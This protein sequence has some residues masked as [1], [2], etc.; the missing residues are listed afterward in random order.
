MAEIAIVPGQPLEISVDASITIDRVWFTVKKEQIDSDDD[1]VIKKNSHTSLGVPT[2]TEIEILSEDNGTATI[3]LL[4]A[5]TK[6]LNVGVY[7][8]DIW[9]RNKATGV[10]TPYLTTDTF[11]INPTISR[12]QFE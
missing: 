9:L 2:P 11:R 5:D 8:Y 7:K 1:A 10:Y 4:N 12:R 3:K 6:D